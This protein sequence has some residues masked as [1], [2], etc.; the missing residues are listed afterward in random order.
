MI[1]G[2]LKVP[3]AD[4]LLL[5]HQTEMKNE[6]T[7]A[8]YN[9][10]AQ[11]ARAHMPATLGLCLRDKATFNVRTL[12]Q[13]VALSRTPDSLRIDVYCLSETTAQDASTL[14]ELTAVSL[15][16]RFRLRTSGD[17]EAA[18]VGYTEAKEMEGAKSAGNVRK[19][20]YLVLSTGPRKPLV[21]EIIRDQS[22]SL[23]CSKA[24]HLDRWAQCFEQQFSLPSATSNSECWPSTERWTVT[25]EPP[26]VSEV[27]EC[28]SLLKR[29]RAGGPDDLS[30]A[31]SKD[32]GELLS[33]CLSG[34]FG[35]IWDNWA[36]S[37]VVTIFKKGTRSECSNYR[38]VSLTPVVTRH[39]VS[40]IL[41]F[42]TVARKGL[43]REN[44]AGFLLGRSCV[45]HIFTLRQVLEQRYMH[46]RPTLVFLDFK[47]TDKFE[48]LDITPYSTPPELPE[49]MRCQENMAPQTAQEIPAGAKQ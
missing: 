31:P 38:G 5:K 9:L 49:V 36:E 3:P 26:S 34:L 41:R 10:N 22:G 17:A 37:I 39:L 33:Q 6:K 45:D 8:S 25:M 32:G 1:E 2:I 20:F 30:P 40:L 7:L 46:G 14:I 4:Q 15:S 11:T 43:T 13:Q 21:T 24:E 19:L 47:G 48:T 12:K 29:H 42:L 28:I 35:P 44:Q 16:F 23:I 18:T 27:S